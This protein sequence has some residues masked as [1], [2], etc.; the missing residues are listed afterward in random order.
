MGRSTAIPR[1][2]GIHWGWLL[3]LFLAA[4]CLPYPARRPGIILMSVIS[5]WQLAQAAWL[6]RANPQSRAM[7]WYAA[8]DILYLIYAMSSFSFFDMNFIELLAWLVLF[9][10]SLT[11]IFTFRAEMEFHF[12]EVDPVGLK[13]DPLTTFLLGTFYFQYHLH[14][15]YRLKQR[16]TAASTPAA[17]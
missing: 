3:V 1:I 14:K 5:V 12:S 2:L 11:A 15:I 7:Y 13:L 17:A 8:S 9:A 6:K 10:V 16:G 4:S